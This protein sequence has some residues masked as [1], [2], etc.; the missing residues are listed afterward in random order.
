MAYTYS[1]I[2]FIVPIQY[3]YGLAATQASD[4]EYQLFDGDPN[5]SAAF[6]T[7]TTGQC[8]IT[9]ADTARPTWL[10]VDG[11]EQVGT[12]T[13][14]G[15]FTPERDATA[16]T[17]PAYYTEEGKAIGG[18]TIA[19]VPDAWTG[20]R[21]TTTDTTS[22][23]SLLVSLTN[24]TAGTVY[25]VDIQVGTIAPTG[26]R[27]GYVFSEDFAFQLWNRDKKTSYSFNVDNE[28]SASGNTFGDWTAALSNQMIKVHTF[29]WTDLTAAKFLVFENFLAAF[30]G[31]IEQPFVL[32]RIAS[33]NEAEFYR[34][35]IQGGSLSYS[36][37]KSGLYDVSFSAKEL[38][39]NY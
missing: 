34:L 26:T 22:R 32:A 17:M 24:G 25:G 3:R 29:Q 13:N 8:S 7:A 30:G 9:L 39:V 23:L 14:T 15:Y 38:S 10:F 5:T 2:K 16:L 36:V 21:R 11:E 6:D 20:F 12:T 37:N 35:I 33:S 19:G 27:L 18:W 1:S 28:R 4:F 31:N